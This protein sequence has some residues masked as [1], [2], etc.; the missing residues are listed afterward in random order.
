MV[1][2]ITSEEYSKLSH[3][4]GFEPNKIEYEKLSKSK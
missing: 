1:C 3:L 2:F 4:I